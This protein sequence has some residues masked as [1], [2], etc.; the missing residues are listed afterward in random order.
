MLQYTKTENFLPINWIALRRGKLHATPHFA[1]GIGRAPTK[2]AVRKDVGVQYLSPLQNTTHP[3]PLSRRE[4]ERSEGEALR[5]FC[6]FEQRIH[7][8][9]LQPFY[10]H[11][12][13]SVFLQKII[14]VFRARPFGDFAS[15]YYHLGICAER[16]FFRWIT[17]Y[18]WIARS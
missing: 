18:Q 8:D 3:Q 16:H 6:T 13:R 2:E 7:V 17:G 12:Q 1:S 9:A 4:K 10:I 11:E 14:F 15:K 5:I